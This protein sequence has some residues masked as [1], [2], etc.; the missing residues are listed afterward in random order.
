MT[1]TDGDALALRQ[2]AIFLTRGR[3]TARLEDM[4]WDSFCEMCDRIGTPRSTVADL[5][6][7]QRSASFNLSS[8]MR[9]AV[10]AYWH[11]SA[12][13]RRASEAAH[14]QAALAAVTAEADRTPAPKGRPRKA[15]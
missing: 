15:H 3:T 10:L 6:D 13:N 14:L 5:I 2:R 9:V 11:S 7:S 4:V 12:K 8:A 1:A